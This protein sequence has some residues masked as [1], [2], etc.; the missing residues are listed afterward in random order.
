M[1]STYTFGLKDDKICQPLR[2]TS[3]PSMSNLI[4]WVISQ[5][6]VAVNSKI[7]K[8]NLDNAHLIFNLK[9]YWKR[10]DIK[11]KQK[12]C[13]M[14][15]MSQERW[16][17]CEGHLMLLA[18]STSWHMGRVWRCKTCICLRLIMFYW[19]QIWAILSG[20]AARASRIAAA[21]EPRGWVNHSSQNGGAVCVQVRVPYTT[22]ANGWPASILIN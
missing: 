10:C 2:Q 5:L 17:Q 14:Y 15:R 20:D 22:R 3:Q 7:K 9:Y 12:T 1:T 13:F 4:T 19:T 21:E 11:K 18:G 8:K 6:E 16:R